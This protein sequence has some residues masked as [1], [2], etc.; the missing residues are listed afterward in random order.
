MTYVGVSKEWLKNH[1]VEFL[2]NIDTSELV[3]E[4]CKRE[5]VV[6]I[7]VPSLHCVEL[8]RNGAARILVV[9]E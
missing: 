1:A 3:E 9:K 7:D 4:L 8:T 2:S 6:V 5:G